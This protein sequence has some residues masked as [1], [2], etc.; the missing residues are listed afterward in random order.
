[1][2]TT[3]EPKRHRD[4]CPIAQITKAMSTTTTTTTMVMVM[5]MTVTAKRISNEYAQNG[6]NKITT[7]VRTTTIGRLSLLLISNG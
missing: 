3:T 2:A 7:I 5:M 1:M 4:R 6:Y